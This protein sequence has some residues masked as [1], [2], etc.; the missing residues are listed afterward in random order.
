M[1]LNRWELQT[2]TISSA[3][4]ERKEGLWR[5]CDCWLFSVSMMLPMA[6]KVAVVLWI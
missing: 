1:G 5:G 3:V 6:R 2:Q 4:E